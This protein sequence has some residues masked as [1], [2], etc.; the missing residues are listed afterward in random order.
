MTPEAK[1]TPGQTVY[2]IER[3]E[4]G[5]PADISGFMFLAASGHAAIVTPFI[6][7]LEELEETLEYL[8]VETAENYDCDL[9][10]FPLEDCY[11]TEEDAEAIKAEEENA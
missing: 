10:V 2:V 8:V 11:A 7:D 3:D 4:C 1:F 6:N 9:S 5:N